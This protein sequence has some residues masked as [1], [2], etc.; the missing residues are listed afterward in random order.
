MLRERKPALLKTWLN[1]V[2]SVSDVTWARSQ[3]LRKF[4]VLQLHQQHLTISNLNSLL[5][6]LVA[7]VVCKNILLMSQ[8][9]ALTAHSITQNCLVMISSGAGAM[10]MEVSTIQTIQMISVMKILI[11]FIVWKNLEE[12]L[13]FGVLVVYEGFIESVSCNISNP[14]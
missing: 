1:V 2:K 5:V 8:H 11:A 9:C 13:F 6:Y 14:S 10:A 3:I 12:K 4:D 7:E